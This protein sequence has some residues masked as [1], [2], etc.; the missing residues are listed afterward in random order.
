VESR[1]AS[2]AVIY[3]DEIQ[4]VTHD[5][6]CS[7][8][9][10]AFIMTESDEQWFVDKGWPIPKRCKTCR[11]NKVAKKQVVEGTDVEEA[12]TEHTCIECTDKFYTTASHEKWYASK[13]LLVPARCPKCIVKRKADNK[14]AYAKKK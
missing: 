8:C 2:A 9:G 3:I 1:G 10:C 12:S 7:A 14:A 6:E 4:E 11:D 5:H 13:N